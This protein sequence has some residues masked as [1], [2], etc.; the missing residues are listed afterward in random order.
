MKFHHVATVALLLTTALPCL[1]QQETPPPVLP[2]IDTTPEDDDFL[3]LK[4]GV[5]KDYLGA[6]RHR[7]IDQIEQA[8][9][10][11]YEPVRP[12]HGYTLPPGAWRVGISSTF[13]HNPSDYGRDDFYE[14]FFEDVAVDFLKTDLT[15]MYGFE[16]EN[17][18]DMTLRLDIPHKFT[19]LSGTGHPWRIDNMNM[20]MEASGEGLGDVS[21]TLKKKWLDQG[22]DPL[23]FSTMLG[24][25]FPTADDDQLFNSSQ[26][27]KVNGVKMPS[28][29][30]IDIFGTKSGERLLPRVAQPGN[31]SWGGRVGFGAT[32]QF[33]RS[34][35]HGGLMYDALSSHDGIDPGDELRY[36]VSYT[37][38]PTT[39]DEWTVDLSL[40]GRWKG[41]ESFPGKVTHPKRDPAT[42]GP[43]IDPATMMP[44]MFTTDRPDF[45]HGNATFFGPSLIHIPSPGTRISF[46]P[47]LR[48]LEPEKG[49]SP[50]WTVGFGMTMTF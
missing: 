4:L 45:E 31:G 10:P 13:G 17:V 2:S 38:P 40:F 11:L 3:F 50:E 48:V 18:R 19:R 43:I 46:S 25:I 7:I 26:T 20:T 49:P 37:F 44:M 24:V 8:I 35:I 36:A 39:S 41:D 42:G 9:P 6:E 27:L 30:P 12:L 29:P 28:A 47:S 16:T 33:E 22:N 34:A 21:L 14:L 23:T 1:A 15:V 5:Q 32:Y